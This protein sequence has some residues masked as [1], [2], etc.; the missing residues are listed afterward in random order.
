MKF[1]VNVQAQAI[2]DLEELHEGLAQFSDS[3][4]ARLLQLLEKSLD[5]LADFPKR[6]PIAPESTNSAIE[7]RNM[8]VGNYRVLFT[9]IGGTVNILRV[10]H[11][12]RLPMKGQELN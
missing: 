12:A 5:S 11:A 8:L 10:R 2:N 1:R 9:I 4:A 3:A 6:H 7:I